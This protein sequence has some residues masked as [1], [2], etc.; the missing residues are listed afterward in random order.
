VLGSASVLPYL[1]VGKAQRQPRLD[2]DPVDDQAND[3]G[4]QLLG[5]ASAGERIAARPRIEQVQ[6]GLRGE[7]CVHLS[8][9]PGLDTVVEDPL[10]GREEVSEEGRPGLAVLIDRQSD[11]SIAQ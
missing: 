11:A 5:V 1:P 2:P 7:G 8:K 9:L 6:Q 3:V 4:G 10:Q